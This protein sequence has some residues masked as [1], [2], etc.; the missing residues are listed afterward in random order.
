MI[1]SKDMLPCDAEK[2]SAEIKYIPQEQQ[3]S[4][5]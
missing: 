5:R 2:K 4:G 3:H 1:P